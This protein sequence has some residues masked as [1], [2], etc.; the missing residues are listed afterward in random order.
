MHGAGLKAMA[1]LVKFHIEAQLL[2]GYELTSDE[3]WEGVS[4]SLKRMQPAVVWSDDE[5]AVA[6][7]S[8]RKFY[9]QKIE[10]R[11]NTPKDISELYTSLKDL[12]VRLDKAA[13]S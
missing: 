1:E 3:M 2:R 6:P 11:Q 12:S 13:A 7:E 8:A 5:A 10:F 4:A 9:G